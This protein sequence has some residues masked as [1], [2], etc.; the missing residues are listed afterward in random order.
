MCGQIPEKT[1]QLLGEKKCDGHCEAN[2][3]EYESMSELRTPPSEKENS[4][5]DRSVPL[6]SRSTLEF[7][8]KVG[9]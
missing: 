2:S 1:V 6:N 4:Q 3:Y 5:M 8:P 7:S 9:Q